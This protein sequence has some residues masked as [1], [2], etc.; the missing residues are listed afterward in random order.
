MEAGSPWDRLGAP[1]ESASDRLG[2]VASFT[3]AAH[4]GF[5]VA[6]SAPLRC[7]SSRLRLAAGTMTLWRWSVAGSS[8]PER[9]LHKAGARAG[10][11][12][13]RESAGWALSALWLG[14]GW[15]KAS[16]VA[17]LRGLGH[18]GAS[19]S[20]PADRE[21]LEALR[22]RA[23]VCGGAGSLA[24]HPEFQPHLALVL[25]QPPA[26]SSAPLRL[27]DRRP[28]TR[29]FAGSRKFGLLR[30]NFSGPTL[31]A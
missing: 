12:R 4:S 20:S 14:P 27:P 2:L 24:A 16:P 19:S 13:C 3:A 8:V 25:S 10:G 15:T 23:A 6:S 11:R 29:A 21:L 1:S 30:G 7:P 26:R 18:G 9:I 5:L 22:R 31:P 17:V 28:P